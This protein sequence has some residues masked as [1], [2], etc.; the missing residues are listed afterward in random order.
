MRWAGNYGW[1]G[2]LVLPPIIG[3]WHIDGD[4]LAIASAAAVVVEPPT[5]RWSVVREGAD[6][7][8]VDG[9]GHHH[10][11]RLLIGIDRCIGVGHGW[12]RRWWWWQWSN[13]WGVG[14]S[15]RCTASLWRWWWR[16]RWRWWWIR[17]IN[18]VGFTAGL[19]LEGLQGA[20]WDAGVEKS[21]D[22]V[23]DH[24]EGASLTLRTI[25][26]SELIH[27]SIQRCP[28]HF[29]IPAR[30]IVIVRLQIFEAGRRRC[31]IEVHILKVFVSRGA[32]GWC[33]VL[34]AWL[35]ALQANLLLGTLAN[36]RD[37]NRH[38]QIL[39]VLVS[40]TTHLCQYQ[41]AFFF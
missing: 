36:C 14:W 26:R 35:P 6:C 21:A 25:V 40:W 18:H 22:P 16:R 11:G 23:I 19:L 24:A 28:S 38:W 12:R 3:W 8:A 29:Q 41:C 5:G 34:G 9:R 4:L 37:F 15:H 20:G 27:R 31:A 10:H 32:P 2:L 30:A 39:E 33:S 1:L 13:W 17:G 7:A